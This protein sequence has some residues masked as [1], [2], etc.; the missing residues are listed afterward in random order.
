MNTFT[1]SKNKG[2]KD[3]AE[4]IEFLAWLNPN[5]S[6]KVRKSSFHEDTTQ[7]IDCW[8][9]SASYSVK[10][11]PTG[12]RTGNVS[13]ELSV[14]VMAEDDNNRKHLRSLVSADR[15][16][17]AI[18]FSG[19]IGNYQ[20]SWF[21][22]GKA[23]FYVFMVGKCIYLASAELLKSHVSNHGFLFKSYLS[24]RVF[25]S[26]VMS[27]HP[28]VNSLSGMLDIGSLVQL[29]I[30]LDLSK[31]FQQWKDG[32]ENEAAVSSRLVSGGVMPTVR[33]RN[34]AKSRY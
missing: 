27:Y 16:D 28:H 5:P 20:D 14:L 13:L 17:E 9:G 22:S 4:V 6:I 15:I 34:D 10:S 12:Q 26:Q 31:P 18:E 19:R 24:D 8:V 1:E 25:K 7:D 33:R 2:M 30:F 29:G 32:K 3:E 11:Q 21:I 23:D